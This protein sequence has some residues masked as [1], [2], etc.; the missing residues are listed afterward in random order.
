[1]DI[2]GFSFFYVR[3][4][5][6]YLNSMLLVCDPKIMVFSAARKCVYIVFGVVNRTS[7]FAI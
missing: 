7:E 6:D 3:N 5:Q 2:T 1:M 4:Q